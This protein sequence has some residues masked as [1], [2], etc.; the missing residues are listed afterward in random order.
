[1]LIYSRATDDSANKSNNNVSDPQPPERAFRVV[2]ELN[3]SHEK[4]CE[5]YVAK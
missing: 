2:E 5:E 4:A 1:M 3:A